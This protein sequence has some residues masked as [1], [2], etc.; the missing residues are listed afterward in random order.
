MRDAGS[1]LFPA[2]LDLLLQVSNQRMRRFS[3]LCFHFAFSIP[4]FSPAFCLRALC[5]RNDG[6]QSQAFSGQSLS[7]G[8]NVFNNPEEPRRINE[9]L[10]S[11]TLAPVGWKTLHLPARWPSH[12]TAGP[13]PV[14]AFPACVS[15][16]T[17]QFPPPCL[18]M[19]PE[20]ACYMNSDLG[21]W[22]QVWAERIHLKA[23]R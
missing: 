6:S 18:L 14:N 21:A 9:V 16:P 23:R 20:N 15:K 17:D 2:V 5:T 1:D 11:V 19:A 13:G 12:S 22:E 7:L 8:K 10:H 4:S 3:L